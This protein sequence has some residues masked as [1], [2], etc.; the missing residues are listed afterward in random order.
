MDIVHSV[1]IFNLSLYK[2]PIREILNRP[3]NKL[4]KKLLPLM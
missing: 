3:G 2:I 1:N 4:E